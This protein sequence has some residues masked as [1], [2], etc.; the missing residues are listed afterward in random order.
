MSNKINELFTPEQI[1]KHGIYS[2][3]VQSKTKPSIDEITNELVVGEMNEDILNFVA[4]L[5]ENKLSPKWCSTNTWKFVYKKVMLGYVG[6]CNSVAA[7][8]YNPQTAHWW[9]RLRDQNK[10]YVSSHGNCTE[11]FGVCGHMMVKYDNPDAEIVKQ[12]KKDILSRREKIAE[13]LKTQGE[14]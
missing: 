12:A 1:E 8:G 6:V 2:N 5:R 13:K 11:C 7:R 9:I 4:W 3:F 10:I 14:S